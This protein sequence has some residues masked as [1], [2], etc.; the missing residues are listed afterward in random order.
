MARCSGIAPG[1][2]SRQPLAGKRCT[3]AMLLLV[4][5]IVAVVGILLA[6]AGPVW[7]TEM[8]RD[9]EADLLWIGDQYARAIGQYYAALPAHQYP[10]QLRD[11]LLDRRQANTVRYLRRLY[12]DPLTGSTEWGTVKDGSGGIT[13][14]Y[15][16][17]KGVPLKQGDFEKDESAFA[18]AMSYADWTFVARPSAPSRA[19]LGGATAQP[20]PARKE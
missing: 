6:V 17:G 7:H 5:F 19:S 4:M 9:K 16:L 12:R 20:T 3:G 10:Q 14:V 18:G 15:S 1:R 8:Q 2:F 11:L 13:G